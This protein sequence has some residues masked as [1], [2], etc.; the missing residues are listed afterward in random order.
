M[1]FPSQGI[2]QMTNRVFIQDAQWM[3]GIGSIDVIAFDQ[4]NI[5][6][7]YHWVTSSQVLNL[8]NYGSYTVIEDTIICLPLFK[9]V[10]SIEYIVTKVDKKYRLLR[11]EKVYNIDGTLSDLRI[12]G[13]RYGDEL[14]KEQYKRFKAI[15]E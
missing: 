9:K 2:T 10:D 14:T 5:Y 4:E 15:R 12:H 1:S 7:E 11:N 8:V 3:D 6:R 13:G